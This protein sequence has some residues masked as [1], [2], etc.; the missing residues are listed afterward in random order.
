M[1]GM[2]QVD[3]LA[4]ALLAL[5]SLTACKS[6]PQQSIESQLLEFKQTC[7][8][9]NDKEIGAALKQLEASIADKNLLKVENFARVNAETAVAFPMIHLLVVRG[10]FETAA[11]VAIKA[12]TTKENRQYVMWKWWEY[13]FGE[14]NDYTGLSRQIGLAYLQQFEKGDLSTRAVI[15]DIY[16]RKNL[17]VDE[18]KKVIEP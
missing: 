12:L 9:S 13:N 8:H 1:N 7:E 4:L 3:G 14:R 16:G 11:E 17:S 18:F 6:T 10:R 5:V 2:K 15:A